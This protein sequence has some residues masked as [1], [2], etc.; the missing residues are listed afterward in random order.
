MFQFPVNAT[1][2]RL[3]PR[4]VKS[5]RVVPTSVSAPV[6]DCVS[7]DIDGDDNDGGHVRSSESC[8]ES[9]SNNGST[10]SEAR[11][12]RVVPAEE[13]T[14]G[15]TTGPLT[16]SQ[17]VRPNIPPLHASHTVDLDRVMSKPPSTMSTAASALSMYGTI[18]PSIQT[19]PSGEFG[20]DSIV[21]SAEFVNYGLVFLLR[22]FFVHV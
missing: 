19:T 14:A 3:I 5:S 22:R 18:D 17:K 10:A 4:G 6:E 12:D 16:A 15:S 20:D 7:E 2:K 8:S 11:S 1:S 21:G 13:Q 9:T